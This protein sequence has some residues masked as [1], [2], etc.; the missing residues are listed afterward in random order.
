MPDQKMVSVKYGYTQPHGKR[1]YN[2]PTLKLLYLTVHQK[3][4]ET[5]YLK[6]R[7]ATTYDNI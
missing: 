2:T 1:L 7:V 4:I 6:W 5:V 3:K